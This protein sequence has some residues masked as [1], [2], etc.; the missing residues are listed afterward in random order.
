[1]TKTQSL[2][3]FNCL[4]CAQPDTGSADY[5]YFARLLALVGLVRTQ[6]DRGL[7]GLLTNQQG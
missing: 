1:M 6:H 4:V 7:A 2:K 3:H 5:V